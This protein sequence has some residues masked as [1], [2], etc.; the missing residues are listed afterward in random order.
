MRSSD[1]STDR[2]GGGCMVALMSHIVVVMGGWRNCASY[3][4][5]YLSLNVSLSALWNMFPSYSEGRGRA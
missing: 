1:E 5:E 4:T 2:V 3:R